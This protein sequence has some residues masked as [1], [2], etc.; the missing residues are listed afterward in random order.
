LREQK[1]QFFVKNIVKLRTTTILLMTKNLLHLHVIKSNF[2]KKNQK[3]LFFF[4]ISMPLLLTVGYSKSTYVK[5][6]INVNLT[7]E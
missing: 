1:Y 7:E 2:R 5:T 6:W 3:N 4:L